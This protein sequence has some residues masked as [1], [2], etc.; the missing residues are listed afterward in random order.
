M[1]GLRKLDADLC[2]PVCA[3]CPGGTVLG[4]ATLVRALSLRQH[5]FYLVP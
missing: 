3:S 4:L 1:M 2:G 5:R